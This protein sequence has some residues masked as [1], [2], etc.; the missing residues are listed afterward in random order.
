VLLETDAPY[1][2]PRG[3][4]FCTIEHLALIRDEAARLRGTTPEAVEESTRAAF[5]AVF[6]GS[7]ALSGAAG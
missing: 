4:E 3:F 7:R 2:P 5:E 6:G 1:Q